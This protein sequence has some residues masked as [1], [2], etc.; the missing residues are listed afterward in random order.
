[1]WNSF[2]KDEFQ[3]WLKRV[4]VSVE[5]FFKGWV[6]EKIFFRHCYFSNNLRKHIIKQKW[7]RNF[8]TTPEILTY[9]WKKKKKGCKEYV[10]VLLGALHYDSLLHGLK[11]LSIRD[12]PKKVTFIERERGTLFWISFCYFRVSTRERVQNIT[13]DMEMPSLRK[14]GT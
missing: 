5:L 4:S 13:I 10:H 14:M 11:W 6:Q 9:I 8:T 1:M 2:S 12:P 3:K 7:Q